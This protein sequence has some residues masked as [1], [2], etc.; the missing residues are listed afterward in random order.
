[1]M[2]PHIYWSRYLQIKRSKVKTKDCKGMPT[3]TASR[4][5]R[6]ASR[7]QRR[8]KSPAKANGRVSGNGASFTEEALTVEAILAGRPSTASCRSSPWGM[9]TAIVLLEVVAFV[10]LKWAMDIYGVYRLARS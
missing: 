9:W 10:W 7:G 6:S 3:R 8:T 1:M 5:S 4:A 2:S